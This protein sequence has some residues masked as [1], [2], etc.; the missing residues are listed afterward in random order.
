MLNLEIDKLLIWFK[1][2]NLSLNLKKTKFIVFKPSQ[3]RSICN[4]QMSIDNQNIVKAKET[5]KFSR[6]NFG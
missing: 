3:K 4:I 6:R 5:I 1:A 2:N